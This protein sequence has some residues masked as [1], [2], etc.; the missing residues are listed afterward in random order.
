M[1]NSSGSRRAG[2]AAAGKAW[3]VFRSLNA[4]RMQFLTHDLF[5]GLTICECDRLA[6]WR[7][8]RPTWVWVAVEA[9][10]NVG[11]QIIDFK[12]L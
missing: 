4:Y 5:A 7:V 3:P 11:M 8:D 12:P 6:R 2:L 9:R 10:L 1:A